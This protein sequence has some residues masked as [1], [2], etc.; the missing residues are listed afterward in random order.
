MPTSPPR[1]VRI[2]TGSRLHF[3]LL[4]TEP[5]FGGAGVMLDQ[6]R[7]VI[8][9]LASDQFKCDPKYRERIEPIMDR[10]VQHF[11]WTE[12]PKCEI[13]V[14]VPLRSHVGLGSGTQLSL[15]IVQGLCQYCDEPFDA[16]AMATSL[17][18][19]G[20]R[21]AVGIHGY[22]Q[23]GMII[24][25]GHDTGERDIP[26]NPIVHRIELP[27][28]WRVGFAIPPRHQDKI[29]GDHEQHQFDQLI[30]PSPS[31]TTALER[32]LID[33]L[34]TAGGRGDFEQFAQTLST[35][36]RRSGELFASVQ[37]GPYNG[38]IITEFVEYLQSRGA[39]G[40][41]QSSWGPGVFCWFPSHQVATEFAERNRE[42]I[43]GFLITKPLQQG[44]KVV[45]DG[46]GPFDN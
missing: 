17:A 2:E 29:S 6:P 18:R 1:R 25:N 4:R 46:E 41:G 32:L 15:G 45:R 33:R 36:N 31:Q 34:A 12:R 30:K 8:E 3:G 44:A 27:S 43:P 20:K 10:M 39:V 14:A 35:Y 19:R 5:P 16:P 22:S 13:Q 23:G 9:I 38:P 11:G 28:H 42:R 37:G 7:G 24:E 21:S 40:V 26:L